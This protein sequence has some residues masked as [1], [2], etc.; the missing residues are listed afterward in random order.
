MKLTSFIFFFFIAFYAIAQNSAEDLISKSIDFHDPK[1]ILKKERVAFQFEESRPN[2]SVRSA[3]AILDP[4]GEFY[5]IQ[6]M[7]N[8]NEVRMIADGDESE[9]YLNG[10]TQ[11]SDQEAEQF[12]LSEDRLSMMASYYRYLWHLPMTLKDPGTIIHPEVNKQDFFGKELLEIKVTYEPT[13]GTD[14]WYFYFHPET[15]ALEGYRFYKSEGANDGEYILLDGIVEYG[16]I[17][18]PMSR[19]WY[20]HKDGKFLG[21]DKLVK[22][23]IL[24]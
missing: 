19:E 17:K 15:S 11:Y 10:K 7:V 16:D 5:M 4:H 6:R 23:N 2:G 24:K 1:G 21:T 20:M 9:F 18:I 14:I 22:L 8:G 13:V 12:R 3:K